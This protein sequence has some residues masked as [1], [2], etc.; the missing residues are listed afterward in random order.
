MAKRTAEDFRNYLEEEL[1]KKIDLANSWSNKNTRKNNPTMHLG[2]LG[3]TAIGTGITVGTTILA[4]AGPIAIALA[5][6]G[7]LGLCCVQ[8]GVAVTNHRHNRKI[9]HKKQSIGFFGEPLTYEEN[10]DNSNQ[11]IQ[12]MVDEVV[13]AFT[14]EMFDELVL[15]VENSKHN[16][17]N[18]VRAMV[19]NGL[20]YFKHFFKEYQK[21]DNPHRITDIQQVA[22]LLFAG[23]FYGNSNKCKA[24]SIQCEDKQIVSAHTMLKILQDCFAENNYLDEMQLP[25]TLEHYQFRI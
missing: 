15:H 7:G 13:N 22:Q 24:F 8:G 2:Y 18:L 12:I 21:S 1:W 17:Q 6:A 20:S 3:K 19:K 4:S 25:E 9:R 5:L 11:S 23:F 16:L 10:R 14:D